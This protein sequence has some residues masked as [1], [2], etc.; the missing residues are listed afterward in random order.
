MRRP[1]RRAPIE[2]IDVDGF[3]VTINFTQGP[4]GNKAFGMMC[5]SVWA[6]AEDADGNYSIKGKG[7]GDGKDY[8]YFTRENLDLVVG[9]GASAT[10]ETGIASTDTYGH[11]LADTVWQEQDNDIYDDF[12]ITYVD[13]ADEE[14]ATRYEAQDGKVAVHYYV[15]D[16]Y[17]EEEGM[18]L[19]LY[20]TGN[21]TSYW[22]AWDG[23]SHAIG[24]GQVDSNNLGTNV[25]YDEAV[26]NWAETG[27]VIVA[28]PDVHSDK[29]KSAAVDVANTIKYFEEN[30]NITKVILSANSN[31]TGISS[32]CVRD[33]TDLVDVFLDYNGWFADGPNGLF[34]EQSTWSKEDVQ[35][36][37]E[38]GRSHLVLQR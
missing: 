18:A 20:V 15:P 8:Q 13:A 26:S 4:A 10:M 14:D 2:S 38:P 28:S 37:A 5:T 22:E 24:D 27:E 23:A 17:N 30:Y 35:R 32:Q 11:M 1:A 25:T 16:T 34:S 7:D 12:S 9:L 3:T 33:F 21:G 6:V 19:V 31:G 36:I 29:N